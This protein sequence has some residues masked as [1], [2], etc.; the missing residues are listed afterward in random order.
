MIKNYKYRKYSTK[1]VLYKTNKRWIVCLLS[2][3]II[4]GLG[5]VVG[6]NVKAIN[7]SQQNNVFTT[8][9]S[10]NSNVNKNPNSS[11]AIKN[12]SLIDKQYQQNFHYNN[13]EGQ[14][15]DIQTI[16]PH[17]N[18]NNKIDYWNGYY[19][20]D[21]ASN[22]KDQWYH[23][24][25]NDFS[26]FKPYDISDPLST[27]NVAIPDKDIDSHELQSNNINDTLPWNT[28]ASGTIINN[29]SKANGQ[30]WLTKDQWNNPILPDA[31]LAYFAT[32]GASTIS[33][34]KLFSVFE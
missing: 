2:F 11:F 3:F 31:K 34:W 14:S 20:W 16:I 22:G 25:T 9:L 28:V 18:A 33:K 12:P 13:P 27:N 6:H 1:K 15:N 23:F 4:L 30:S 21:P 24:T 32:F 29:N 5:I 8:T 26:H 19:L 7:L 17:Y 10:V